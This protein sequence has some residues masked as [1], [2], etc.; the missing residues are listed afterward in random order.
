MDPSDTPTDHM[1]PRRL[2]ELSF[3]PGYDSGDDILNSFYV[4]VLRRSVHY[5]R[6][7]GY[8]RSSS[9]ST[10]ARGLSRFIA[11]GGTVRL[12]VG[13]ELTEQDAD[14]L[15]GHGTIP[16]DLAA[17]L[18]SALVTDDDVDRRR[19][20]VLAWLVRQERLE[21]KVAVAVDE[22]GHYLVGD[23]DP[24]FHEKIGVLRDEAG[25][26]VAFQGSVNESATA[27]TRNFESFSVFPSWETPAHFDHWAHRFDER[28]AGNVAGYDVLDLPDVVRDELLTY[29]PAVIPAGRD[30]EERLE[31]V[32]PGLLAR[33]LEVAPRLPTAQRLP[34]ETIPLEPFPHQ[35]QVYERLAGTYPRSW[36]LADEVG[37]GK[38]VSAGLSL[39][40]L[41]LTGQ[42]E[43]ALILAPANVAKQWQDELFEKFG[44]WVPRLEGRRLHGAH[45]DDVRPLNPGENPYLTE[46]LLIASSHLARRRDQ[47]PLVLAAA[48]FDLLIVDE[49]HHARRRGFSDP[50]Q[51]RPSLLLSLLD[52]LRES[53][54]LGA[55]WLLTATPM[56]VDPIELL[57][58]LRQ[59][60]L[61]GPLA[62]W[63]SFK[64]LYAEL[65]KD[66]A[67]RTDWRAIVRLLAETPL[68]APGPVE[69]ELLSRIRNKIG[70]VAADRIEK[71]VSSPDDPR[72]VADDLGPAG[73]A[74]L[75]EWLRLR[76]P[77]GQYVTRHS[78]VTLKRYRDQGLLTEPVADRDVDDID[79]RFEPAEKELYERLDSLID[80]LLVAHGSKQQAGFILTVYRRRLTSSWAAI[81]RTL[82]K[83]LARESD[84]A[85]QLELDVAILDEL[86]ADEML[87]EAVDEESAVPLTP[88]DLTEIRGYLAALDAVPDTKFDE[89]QTLIGQARAEGRAL[90]VFTQFTDTLDAIRDRLVGAYGPELAT[91][92]G[93][94]GRRWDPEQHTWMAVSKQELV[95]DVREAR[96]TVVLANDAASEGL[97]LQAASFLVNYDLP[98]NPM[99]IEQRIGRI[100]RIG[101]QWSTVKVR[102]FTIPGT[103]EV[104]V[105]R[106]LRGRIDAFH[107][108]IGKLQP[109]LGATEKAVRDAYASDRE[110]RGAAV[111]E[112]IKEL[113]AQVDHLE[114]TGIDLTDEDPLPIP[115]H[116]AS[117]VS[118][119]QLYD[120]LTDLGIALG[121]AGRPAI[122]DG[123][124]SRDSTDWRALATYGHPALADALTA[125]AVAYDADRSPVLIR[126]EGTVAAAIR[127]DRSPPE[128]VLN[129]GQLRDLGSPVARDDAELLVD[130]QLRSYA[131][132]QRAAYEAVLSDRHINR[133]AA[134]RGDF[135]RF[136]A[137]L[138]ATRTAIA[139]LH[140]GDDVDPAVA[141]FDLRDE[142]SQLRYIETFAR[143]L[144]VPTTEMF[145]SLADIN[146]RKKVA[147]VKL[148]ARRADHLAA[149]QDLIAQM[150]AMRSSTG[151]N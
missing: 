23:Q 121:Q 53:G 86:G 96:V 66:D 22:H 36:L 39:R 21:I 13:A 81:R 107:D 134:L 140:E 27:W 40:R 20:A 9:L 77:V 139:S 11:S 4:P 126:S 41:L 124:A 24:Y 47:R 16:P 100:D 31:P 147:I 91:Y 148:Q 132:E 88:N 56:Q 137:D 63:S 3:P 125:A 7:V 17:R 35:Q 1:V 59:V 42:I 2:R 104:D 52:E 25:D 61:T 151:E 18:A 146:E 84:L 110:H 87:G 38:T 129:V 19:L 93:Q 75:R 83:R 105:Y 122:F 138:L 141:W 123:G 49:A 78:R 128:P 117:P 109:I 37:L 74:E 89:L 118:W 142:Q 101:Q 29:A 64:R 97:N 28:W 116:P 98:W 8:F 55:T 68:P 48:P 46:R 58:L 99:R 26:G 5:D 131:R 150:Q 71:F 106:A 113:L 45:P 133:Q 32:D 15:Q 143:Q 12:L 14:A 33:Y 144:G 127:A 70:L 90:I 135:V 73:R 65:A 120:S 30:P 67:D 92:T 51:Y 85:T 6:S 69:V 57:D 95:A 94:G 114:S 149:F 108:L 82:H 44:L 145:P 10:A 102:N 119:T 112:Q 60:G 136:V 76:S 34:T 62:S 115:N 130:E 54:K 50:T 80:R 103:V 111:D 79:I 43:R 72:E